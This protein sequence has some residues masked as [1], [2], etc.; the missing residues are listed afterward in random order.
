MSTTN[1][2]TSTNSGPSPDSIIKSI[3]SIKPKFRN[4]N[5]ALVFAIHRL[6][7]E[8][9][10]IFAGCGDKNDETA[11][12]VSIPANWNIS[13]D[14]Y[15]FRYK[16]KDATLLLKAIVL[17]GQVLLHA[18]V[19]GDKKMY[20][21]TLTVDEFI[22]RDVPLD[23]YEKLF[24]DIE[25]LM[26]LVTLDIIEPLQ[27]LQTATQPAPS[28]REEPKKAQQDQRD[29]D[30]LRIPPRGQPRPN[31]LIDTSYDRPFITPFGTGHSDVFPDIPSGP[32]GLFGGPGSGNLIG[33]HHPGFGISPMP[34]MDPR[35]RGRGRGIPPGAR[36]DPYGPGNQFG[37]P[38]RDDMPPPKRLRIR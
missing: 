27:P 12:D 20:N 29:Y 19:I 10:F 16:L 13:D 35:N 15:T 34:G 14:S 24:K 37:E 36:F 26:T 30:P 32:G 23:N 31:P 17:E 22:N 7:K 9:G 11:N 5:D 8:N 38:D 4:A 21:M 6:M 25:T 2:G 18:L 28:L 33:P 1:Q 3:A